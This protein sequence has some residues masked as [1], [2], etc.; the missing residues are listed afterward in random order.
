MSCAAVLFRLALASCALARPG[1]AQGR[2]PIDDDALVRAIE[3]RCEIL[4]QEGK[5]VRLD[6]LHAQAPP[7]EVELTLPLRRTVKLEPPELYE[8]VRASALLVGTYYRCNECDLWHFDAA[9]GFALTDDGAVAT[10]WH[11]LESDPERRDVCAV[12]AD[13]AGNVWPIRSVLAANAQADVCIVATQARGHPPLPLRSG[14]RVGERVWCVSNP[15]HRFAFFSEGLLARWFIDREPSPEADAAAGAGEARLS[16]GVPSFAVTL[17]FALGSSGA[18]I[19]DACGN[20]VGLAQATTTIVYDAEAA[21][22]DV[23]MV[24]KIAAPA[25]ALCDLVRPPK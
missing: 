22:P 8:S 15:D 25:A 5:L 13:Y 7:Q 17:D 16:P 9:S 6:D 14:A 19:V 23:Q 11:V 20:A 3:A 24:V 18:A 10:C 2:A 12:V 1:S 4:R 21:T